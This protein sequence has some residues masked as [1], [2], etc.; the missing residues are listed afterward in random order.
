MYEMIVEYFIK[1]ALSNAIKRF[2]A[3]IPRTKKQAL[4]AKVH[5]LGNRKMSTCNKRKAEEPESSTS[6]FKCPVC[7]NCLEEDPETF[8]EQS[9]ACDYC[10]NWYHCK[11]VSLTGN[12]PCFKKKVH[13]METCKLQRWRKI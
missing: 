1:I 3:N 8:E 10:N 9:I 2:K 12:E 4:R 7:N 11:C 13:K 6:V 5:A